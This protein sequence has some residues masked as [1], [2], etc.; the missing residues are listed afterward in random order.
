M[1][2]TII[3]YTD[4]LSSVLGEEYLDNFT[5]LFV[6]WYQSIHYKTQCI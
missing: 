6:T 5:K 2:P 3:L 1:F 4:K